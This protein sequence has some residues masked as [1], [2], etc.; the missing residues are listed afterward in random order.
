[1][2][3]FIARALL[4]AASSKESTVPA[5][6]SVNATAGTG[7][8]EGEGEIG[9]GGGVGE[10]GGI[11][12]VGGVRGAPMAGSGVHVTPPKAVP[13]VHTPCTH[14]LVPS[15]GSPGHADGLHRSA[16]VVGHVMLPEIPDPSGGE[17]V[18]P[19]DGHASQIDPPVEF[20]S[21]IS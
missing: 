12:G 7:G 15:H 14:A 5:T 9:G 2:A 1:M 8:D 18:P 13:H 3:S 19:P 16:E 10:G 6:T 11:G 4:K 17:T 20:D 21:M